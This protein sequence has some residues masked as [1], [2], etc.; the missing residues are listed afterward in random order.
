MVLGKLPVPGL[1]TSLENSRV[2]AYCACNRCRWRLFEHFFSHLSVL[3]FPPL[4]GRR[5]DIDWNT[6]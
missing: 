5:P 4:S 2:M 3:F 1:L 6:V